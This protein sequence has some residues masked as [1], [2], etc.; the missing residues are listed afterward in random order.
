[1]V[2]HHQ[3]VLDA[4]IEMINEHGAIDMK[5]LAERSGISRATLYRY[6][7]DRRQ[8]EGE[9]AAR[10]LEQ[11][12]R[13]V[14]LVGDDPADRCQTAAGFL[15]AHPGEAAAITRMAT[16]V[17]IDVLVA[18]AELVVGDGN[19]APWIIGVAA[20]SRA[21]HRGDEHELLG[22]MVAAFAARH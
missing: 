9:V 20:M 3:G 8:V 11:M 19:Y 6:Y 4:A 16:E 22:A 14:V 17:G 1:M 21:A 7:A 13:E 10:A 5:R 2:I 12:V 15:I 18:T